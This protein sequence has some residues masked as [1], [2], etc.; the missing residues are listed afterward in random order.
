MP[1]DLKFILDSLYKLYNE[2]VEELKIYG[3]N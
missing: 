2:I 3:Y 1:N